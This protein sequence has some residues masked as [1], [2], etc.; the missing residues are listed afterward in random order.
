VTTS[1]S[2]PRIRRTQF[3]FLVVL[4]LVA[5]SDGRGL[6]GLAGLGAQSLGFVLVAA[7]TLYRMWSSVFIAGRK[8]VEIVRDG[9]YARCRHPLYLGSLVAGIGLALS[10]RSLVLAVALPA[11]L[12]G[13]MAVAIRR[14]ER[15]LARTH[16]RAW[17]DYAARVPV[18]WP[19]PGGSAVPGRRE[20]DLLIYRK[21]F[22]D[23]ATVLG[24]W[25]LIVAVDALRTQGLW[26][27]LFTLP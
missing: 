21:S 19:G 8:D 9:P 15:F 7:G 10:T 4:F 18:L 24:L 27:P 13:L 5:T 22:L 17:T 26:A 14:E 16:G 25:F 6:Q 12:A 23:A 3:L 20:V 2:T 11:V 1:A